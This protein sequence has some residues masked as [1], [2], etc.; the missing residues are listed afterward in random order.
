MPEH[1]S[2]RRFGVVL[3]GGG[4]SVVSMSETG[5]AT[6]TLD[7]SASAATGVVP[8]GAADES[9]IF[10]WQPDPQTSV[11]DQGETCR[12]PRSR[13]WRTPL[14]GS[15]PERLAD[16]LDPDIEYMTSNDTALFWVQENSSG[17][18]AIVTMPK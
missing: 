6:T 10:W 18:P 8:A 2:T 14:D 1:T 4:P 7:P 15:S 11:C 12:P 16:G 3:G 13:I 5:G 9:G 17:S